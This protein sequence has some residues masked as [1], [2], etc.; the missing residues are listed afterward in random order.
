MSNY[1]YFVQRSDGAIK[2]GTTKNLF[3]RLGDLRREH[4]KIDVLGVIKGGRAK[5]KILHWCLNESRLDGEWFAL[6][7]D[8]QNIIDNYAADISTF[9]KKV[10]KNKSYCKSGVAYEQRITVNFPTVEAAEKVKQAAAENAMSPSKWIIHQLGEL[11]ALQAFA[12]I[13]AG[14]SE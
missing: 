14:L 12:R 6:T 1:I 13:M 10:R 11:E 4:G 8:I 7:Y 2:I 5:E 3:V 9:K